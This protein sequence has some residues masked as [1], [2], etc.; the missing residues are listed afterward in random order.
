MSQAVLE[1]RNISNREMHIC[2]DD[3]NILLIVRFNE[4]FSCE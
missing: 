3:G 1:G 4:T 2:D